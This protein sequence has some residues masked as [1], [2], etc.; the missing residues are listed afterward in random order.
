M[1]A[2]FFF[3]LIF[4]ECVRDKRRKMLHLS[5]MD[6]VFSL[7]VPQ[8]YPH[9]SLN[10]L[11]LWWRTATRGREE[12]VST[13]YFFRMNIKHNGIL[14]PWNDSA[15]LLLTGAALGFFIILSLMLHC[16]Y[17]GRGF[18]TVYGTG[19]WACIYIVLQSTLQFLPHTYTNAR[20]V[21]CWPAN[22][23][24][25]SASYPKCPTIFLCSFTHTLTHQWN[26]HQGFSILLK[27]H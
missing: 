21:R 2:F 11:G 25:N 27:E 17:L 1:P 12:S 18:R 4:F 8:K 24:Q 16:M 13:M 9:S 26:S 7:Y 14:S 22:L 6:Y 23:A 10:I 3:L 19:R 5:Q 15:S 20:G